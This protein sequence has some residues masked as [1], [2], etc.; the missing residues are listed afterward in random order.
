MRNELRSSVVLM[1]TGT[2]A[3]AIIEDS[4]PPTMKE[5]RAGEACAPQ[6]GAGPFIHPKAWDKS[7]IGAGGNHC[8]HKSGCHMSRHPVTQ[9]LVNCTRWWRSWY[10]SRLRRLP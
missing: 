5:M 10:G 2:R 4:F 9:L 6:A 1:G 7:I 8:C 3:L